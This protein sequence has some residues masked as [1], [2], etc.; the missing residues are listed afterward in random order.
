MDVNKQG[1]ST[2]ALSIGES[3]RHQIFPTLNESQFNLLM[4]Y[5]E[6]RQYKAQDVLFSEGER[7]IAMY[8]IISGRI[9]IVRTGYDGPHVIA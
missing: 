5:D 1:S 8:A 7:H 3:R 2:Q 9:D 6:L 4:Q